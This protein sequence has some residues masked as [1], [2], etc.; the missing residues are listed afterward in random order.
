MLAYKFVLVVLWTRLKC[1]AIVSLFLIATLT[2][3]KAAGQSCEI[4][5]SG[6]CLELRPL[7]CHFS[8][9]IFC[10][11]SYLGGSSAMSIE[12]R[13][14]Q[15]SGAQYAILIQGSP[16]TPQCMPRTH[17]PCGKA[18]WSAILEMYEGTIK[19]CRPER[20]RE[21]NCFHLWLLVLVSEYY[22]R[23]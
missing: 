20:H 16:S 4:T 14:S 15:S 7:L 9:C 2:L 21:R 13:E 10:Q 5:G 12:L 23:G 3:R 19:S 17:L 22:I 8:V 1:L 11:S 18:R 6:A